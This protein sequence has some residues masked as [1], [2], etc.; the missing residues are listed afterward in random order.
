MYYNNWTNRQKRA[1]I[2]KSYQISQT[3]FVGRER[4]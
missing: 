3:A 4:V 1:T 2:I